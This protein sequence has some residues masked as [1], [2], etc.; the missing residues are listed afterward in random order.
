[1]CGGGLVELKPYIDF[2]ALLTLVPKVE[3]TVREV[4]KEDRCFAAKLELSG[5]INVT[6]K[7]EAFITLKDHK[8]NFK[9]EP[10]CRL[11]NLVNLS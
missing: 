11:I 8:P 9:D 6:A 4:T 10:T 1:M 7:R 5:R 3:T 2:S